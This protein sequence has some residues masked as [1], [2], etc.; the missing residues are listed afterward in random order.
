M[1]NNNS[2]AGAAEYHQNTSLRRRTS[3]RVWDA[4]P[5]FFALISVFAG[6]RAWFDAPRFLL[7]HVH[8]RMHRLDAAEE[9]QRL[10][11][12]PGGANSPARI[13]FQ[14]LLVHRRGDA[15]A[16]DFGFARLD[17]RSCL[18]EARFGSAQ[19]KRRRSSAS[20][21]MT[22]FCSQS[23]IRPSRLRISIVRMRPASI[24]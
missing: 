14:N 18:C 7:I 13:E 23:W 10:G 22:L 20:E 3:E 15:A 5:D 4:S 24:V 21:L 16:G 12:D 19:A 1:P 9:Q 2:E 17:A 6:F 8:A 11:R